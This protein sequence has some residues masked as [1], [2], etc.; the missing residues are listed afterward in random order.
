MSISHKQVIK[1]GAK[2]TYKGIE[3]IVYQVDRP[4]GFSTDDYY[5]KSTDEMSAIFAETSFV[6]IKNLKNAYYANDR[7]A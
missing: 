4:I 1:R 7:Q 3:A 5:Y 2:V 6:A